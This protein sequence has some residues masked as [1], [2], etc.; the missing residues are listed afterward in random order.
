[1]RH[2]HP[3]QGHQGNPIFIR[4]MAAN[5]RWCIPGNDQFVSGDK[6]DRPKGAVAAAKGSGEGQASDQGEGSR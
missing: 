3:D 5:G 4:V 2:Q 6:I 1:M